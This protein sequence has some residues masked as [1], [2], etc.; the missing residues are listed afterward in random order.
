MSTEYGAIIIG[1]GF[2]GCSIARYLADAGLTDIVVLERGQE[3]MSRAS[4][5]NQA[6][7]HQGYH[8][9]RSLLTAL[10]ARVNFSRFVDHYPEAV[11]ATY[12][13][14][15]GIAR[16]RSN[17]TADQFARF[18]ARIGA[19]LYKP[20][21]EIERLFN[22]QLVER[23]FGVKEFVF[24]ALLLRECVTRELWRRRVEIRSAS[25]V[26][27]V[28]Q[29]RGTL[30]VELDD[31][32]T[33]RA[34][35]VFNCAYSG[36]NRVLLAS[37]LPVIPLKH[38]IAEL[39]LVKAPS[40]FG[41][42]GVTLMCGPFFSLLPFPAEGVHSLSHVRYTPHTEW[43]DSAD[44][45]P[46]DAYG[47]LTRMPKRTRFNE[48]V[49]DAARFVHGLAECSYV[50]SL[51]EVKSI[52]PRSETDDSRPIL[53]RRNHGLP[54]LTCVLGSKIDSVYDVLD[55]IGQ[56]LNLPEGLQ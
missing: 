51:W 56:H 13:M 47:R 44:K 3:L 15:Y 45:I 5:A 52:M 24:D 22:P 29:D 26:V 50:D 28:R 25:D 55:E 17:V 32:T 54:A 12:D 42:A 1:G 35:R 7:I 10:R 9:P 37:N 41:R 36:L 39:A 33:L 6:R 31:G 43:H 49:R 40:C 20:A 4:Y 11:V 16:D 23:V 2:Y 53:Y 18:C 48:M 21:R 8:Y 46:E 19:P 38:E 30:L 14:Y 34:R 27:T